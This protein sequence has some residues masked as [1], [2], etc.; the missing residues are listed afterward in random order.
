MNAERG[1]SYV[2]RF[3]PSPTGPLH[4]G[5]L[6]AAL[7]SYLD[8]KAH[9]GS[10]LLRIEDIDPLRE[11]AGAAQSIVETLRVFGMVSTQPVSYQSQHSPRYQ[12]A[13]D[14]L[15]AAGLI[16]RCTCSRKSYIGKKVYPGTCRTRERERLTEPPSILNTIG[17]AYRFKVANIA[18]RWEDR[19]KGPQRQDLCA[20]VGDFIVK[21]V[22]GLWA[23]Q[24]AVVVDDAFQEVS[25][26]V[27]GDDLADS[28]A[29]QIALQHAL[30]LP[31]PSYLHVPVVLAA[32]GQKLSKQ[33]GA[34]ALD[35]NQPLKTLLLAWR[36][37]AGDAAQFK[38]AS[39]LTGLDD[40]YAHCT[41]HWAKLYR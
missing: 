30:G 29:R 7:A 38:L 10:W 4:F 22:D 9:A 2:G 36:H 8:A 28:T 16:Y 37:L 15:Q 21:R 5:S 18:T 27:R 12:E 20:E 1:Q 39:N 6:V 3:A 33:T 24:L 14:L 40:F 23:Y 17:A 35:L 11:P 26:I 25:H 32:D 34:P 41:R 13:L 19:A 31:T